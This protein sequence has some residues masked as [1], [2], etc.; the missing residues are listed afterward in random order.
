M[1]YDL[2]F[3]E[4]INVRVGA[5]LVREVRRAPAVSEASAS[6]GSKRLEAIIRRAPHPGLRA[7]CPLPRAAVSCPLSGA[8][9]QRRRGASK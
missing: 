8:G 3:G 5:G 2:L 7:P 9:H 1:I 6:W 4:L